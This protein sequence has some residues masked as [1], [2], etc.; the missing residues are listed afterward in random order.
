[1]KFGRHN[2]RFPLL[3]RVGIAGCALEPEESGQ[4][5]DAF[6]FWLFLQSGDEFP[7]QYQGSRLNVGSETI[8][9]D[10]L[11]GLKLGRLLISRFPYQ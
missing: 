10:A 11:A 5:F 7:R 8:C 1:L 3:L 4:V 2:L 6:R 9:F